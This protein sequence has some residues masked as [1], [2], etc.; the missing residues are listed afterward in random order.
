MTDGH[1]GGQSQRR[2][3]LLDILI[4]LA[5]VLPFLITA[6][7]PLV[8]LPNLLA[9][10]HILNEWSASPDLQR[11]YYYKIDI[12]PNLALDI[13]VFAAHHVMPI[14]SAV[15]LFCVAT[16]G[17]IFAGT[18]L[19]NRQLGGEQSRVYRVAPFLSSGGPHQF[20]AI[21]TAVS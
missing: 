5:A 8:D 1:I 16:L 20:I 12:V 10:Q 14:D 9:R 21:A 6:H 3:L 18:R 2:Q 11:F 19:V 15:R 4:G 7:L 17:L 13:F